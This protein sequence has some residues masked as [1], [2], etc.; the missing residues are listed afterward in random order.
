[1]K[2][3][4]YYCDMCGEEIDISY[5]TLSIFRMPLITIDKLGRGTIKSKY[6]LCSDCKYDIRDIIEAKR[7]EN[8]NDNKRP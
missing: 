8:Q 5:R 3:T 7:K 6:D 2:V 4:K 1:M